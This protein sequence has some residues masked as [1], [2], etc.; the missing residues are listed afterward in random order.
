VPIVPGIFEDDAGGLIASYNKLQLQREINLQSIP[1]G[2]PLIKDIDLS[3]NK[4]K[5]EMILA[6]SKYK[7]GYVAVLENLKA[8]EMQANSELRNLPRKERQLL[9]ITRQ[10]KVM[11]ELYATLLQKKLQTSISTASTLSNIQLLESG[12]SSG[13]AVSPNKKS[14]YTTA[15]LIGL[16]IPLCFALLIEYLNDKIRTRQDILKGTSAPLLGEI[17]H[18]EGQKTLVVSSRDRKFISEQFRIIRTS[19]QYVLSNARQ[20]NTILVTSC[21]SGEGKSFIATNIAAVLAISGKKTVLIEFD[22]RKPRLMKG[23]GITLNDKRGLTHYLIGKAEI[24]EIIHPVE[25]TENLYII[26]CG[27]IPPNPAELI[28]DNRLKLLFDQLEQDFEMVIIDTPPVGMVS[29]G[30]ILGN[31]ADATI[32]VLRHNYTFK[33]QLEFIQSVYQDKKLPHMSIVVNDVKAPLG[34]GNYGGYAQ[35]GYGYSS[36][37]H[38]YFESDQ[39]RK[40]SWLKRIFGR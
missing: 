34:Y 19:L 21:M 22:I 1:V 23:L 31:H 2:S 38:Q 27:P 14:F 35:Y 29:D 18:A 11:E 8:A 33:N 30:Y 13:V 36:G 25:G 5:A 28:L 9:D 26:P 32:F 16:I 7:E 4:I 3:L 6:L 37:L 15:C 12:Y 20:T 17:G 40:G 24:N 10:Q 39:F